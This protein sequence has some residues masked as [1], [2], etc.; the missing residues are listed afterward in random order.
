MNIVSIAKN[1]LV[2][3]YSMAITDFLHI[4]WNY[5]WFV[6]HLFSVP[7]VLKSLFAPFKRL[8]EERGS[9]L[10]HPEQFFS[11]LVVNIIMRLVGFFLRSAII[12]AAFLGFTTVIIG[13]LMFLALWLTLPVLIVSFLLN[14]ISSLLS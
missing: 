2:W 9:I 11:G 4:W 12:T 5:L 6:N 1:Y 7:D 14:G 3:H 10:L 8:Q 13:G